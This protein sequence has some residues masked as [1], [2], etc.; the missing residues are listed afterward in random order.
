[1]L[2][3]VAGGL[4]QKLV[5]GLVQLRACCMSLFYSEK[6]IDGE[7]AAVAEDVHYSPHSVGLSWHS[8]DSVLLVQTF[9][10]PLLGPS[11]ESWSGSTRQEWPHFLQSWLPSFLSVTA[12]FYHVC[13]GADGSVG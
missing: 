8:S 5:E 11:P 10:C 13:S 2:L 12:S 4:W 6:Q 3:R 9:I 1:M 7:A